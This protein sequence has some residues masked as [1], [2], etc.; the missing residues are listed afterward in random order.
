MRSFYPIQ[1]LGIDGVSTSR[2]ISSGFSRR[3]IEKKSL[4]LSLSLTHTVVFNNINAACDSNASD[5]GP[6]A[7]HGRGH[8]HA[9]RFASSDNGR[10]SGVSL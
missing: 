10:K 4:P 1:I 6:R 8:S 7:R 3:E 5:D 9:E 2:L